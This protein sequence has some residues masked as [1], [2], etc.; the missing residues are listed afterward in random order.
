M[1]HALD[2]GARVVVK[3]GS[4]SLVAPE[5]GIDPNAVERVAA[6]VIDLMDNGFPTAVVTSGAIAAGFPHAGFPVRPTAIADLQVAASVGQTKLMERY[7]NL[8]GEVGIPIGQVL[9]TRDVLGN[10]HQYLNARAALDRMM[11]RGIVP[12]VNEN[13]TV[14]VDEVRFGDNDRLAA[15]TSHLVGAAML[16][17]LTD[18]DGLYTA[19]PN[20][21]GSAELLAAVR[22]SD[23]VLDVLT[24]DDRKGVLGSGGVATKVLAARMAAFSGIPTVIAPARAT[25]SVRK[26]VTGEDIGTWVDPRPDPMSSRKLW[27]AF[28]LPSSGTI[29]IDAGAVAALRDRGTS[30]LGVGVV[31]RHG[32]FLPGDAVEIID[33]SG[34]MVAK[35]IARAGSHELGD[36]NVDGPVVH[37]DDLVL[38]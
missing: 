3:V 37:R 29:T 21:D 18:T 14:A 16:I 32:E 2:P 1:R 10:R 7:A 19:D 38:F 11:E 4:S 26:A 9:L 24:G 23:T 34:A 6:Q 22:H 5:G 12:V 13:D 28:G 30:L 17:I 36:G 15:V 25:D 27:I 20:V 31:A 35:G 33:E 8:F